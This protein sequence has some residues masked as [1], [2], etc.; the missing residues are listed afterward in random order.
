MLDF[1]LGVFS[2]SDPAVTQGKDI[3]ARQLMDTGTTTIDRRLADQPKVRARLKNMIGR[4]Y[5]SIGALD[6]SELM[7]DEALVPIALIF[8]AGPY[9]G[10][11]DGDVD[12]AGGMRVGGDIPL[13]LGIDALSF[14]QIWIG[15]RFG[16]EHVFG[17]LGVTGMLESAAATGFRIGGVFGLA[18]GF[19]HVHVMLELTGGWESWSGDLGGANLEVSGAVL[20]PAFAIRYRI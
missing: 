20:V 11:F 4:V 5:M 16:V 6:Q 3:T 17:D 1:M 18:L 13:L 15:A 10:W 19:R 14:L 12:G 8:G 7:L 2:A 9:V